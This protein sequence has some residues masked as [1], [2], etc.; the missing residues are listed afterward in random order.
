MQLYNLSFSNYIWDVV[1]TLSKCV[2]IR[3]TS[4]VYQLY[5]MEKF[6]SGFVFAFILSTIYPLVLYNRKLYFIFIYILFNYVI[7]NLCVLLDTIWG[8]HLQQ[9]FNLQKSS[10]TICLKSVK[11]HLWNTWHQQKCS[12]LIFDFFDFYLHRL[13]Q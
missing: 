4:D 1:F 12:I 8:K 11:I 13:K 2:H 3:L 6:T 7:L 9:R 10:F 5:S